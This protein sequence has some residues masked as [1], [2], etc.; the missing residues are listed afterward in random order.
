MKLKGVKP[1]NK[2]LNKFLAEW[3]LTAVM[4]TDFAYLYKRNVVVWTPVVSVKNDTDFQN[5]FES[6]GCI[7]KCDVFLYSILHEIGHSQTFDDLSEADYAYSLDRKSQEISNDEYFRLPDELAATMW[8]V[9]FLNNNVD[10][11]RVWWEELQPLFYDFYQKNGVLE[12]D[13]GAE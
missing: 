11:V 4:G 12:F 10:K 1:I 6:L 7:V 9:D 3:G 8:A 5:F 13:E 2:C